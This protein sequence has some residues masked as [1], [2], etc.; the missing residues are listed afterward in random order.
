LR[1]ASAR[2]FKTK[3]TIFYLPQ[4]AAPK[5]ISYGGGGEEIL[6]QMIRIAILAAAVLAAGNHPA[7]MT[8]Q[9]EQQRQQKFYALD[10]QRLE[11]Y[12]HRAALNALLKV[13]RSELML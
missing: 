5:R 10:L 13:C 1:V 8:D 3:K 9:N 7:G 4:T 11:E 12:W 2:F 6:P